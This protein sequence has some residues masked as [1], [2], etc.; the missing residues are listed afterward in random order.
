MQYLWNITYSFP[1]DIVSIMELELVHPIQTIWD[2]FQKITIKGARRE[3]EAPA[4]PR[5]DQGGEDSYDG[6]VE[7][8]DVEEVEESA[9]DHQPRSAAQEERGQVQYGHVQVH[10]GAEEHQAGHRGEGLEE[11]RQSDGSSMD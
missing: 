3:A 1:I 7:R 2:H 6:G 4:T 5:P 9:G 8:G 10:A 11:G